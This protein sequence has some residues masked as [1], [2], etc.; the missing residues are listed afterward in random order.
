MLT[1]ELISKYLYINYKRFI[2]IIMKIIVTDHGVLFKVEG[3]FVH[4]F[5]DKNVQ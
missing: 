3:S 1:K 4:A 2:D 5:F